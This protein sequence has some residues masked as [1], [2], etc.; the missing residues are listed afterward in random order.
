MRESSQQLSL[1]T[2][3]TQKLFA[4]EEQNQFVQTLVDEAIEKCEKMNVDPKQLLLGLH[5]KQTLAFLG[6]FSQQ[7]QQLLRN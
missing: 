7:E 3:A 6:K 4:T 1:L 2:L 5:L